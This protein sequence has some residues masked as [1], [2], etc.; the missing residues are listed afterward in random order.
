MGLPWQLQR[1]QELQLGHCSRN[2]RDASWTIFP[3]VCRQC[4]VLQILQF[5][6]HLQQHV[7]M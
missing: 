2:F 1:M 3:T 6:Q 5:A 4:Q 7:S